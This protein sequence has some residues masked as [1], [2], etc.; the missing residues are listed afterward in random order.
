MKLRTII[1]ILALIIIGVLQSNYPV[2]LE[3]G[4]GG[5]KPNFLLIYII[6]YSLLNG[7]YEGA[8]IGF[9]AGFVQDL[10]TGKVIG[11][12]ALIGMLFGMAIG[13]SNKKI[14]K[15]NFI[16]ASL[17]IFIGTI[18]YELVI[19]ATLGIQLFHQNNM[20]YALKFIVFPEALYN[21]IISI[22]VYWVIGLI[23]KRTDKL[24]IKETINK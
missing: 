18:V 16:V 9:T 2:V 20:L 10:L 17:V 22:G 8:M 21:S 3:M 15:E 24:L 13:W 4:Y 11:I 7:S 6:V 12:Y 14:Y 1:N 19:A 23:N 5:I